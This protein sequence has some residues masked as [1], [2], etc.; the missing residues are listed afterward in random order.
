MVTKIYANAVAKYNEGKLLDEEKLRRLADSDFA[1]AVKML[2]DYGYGGGTADEKSYDAD[3][4]ISKETAA[5][6]DY[7]YSDAPDPYLARVL[8]ARFLFGNAKAYRKAKTSGVLQAEAVY[9]MPDDEVREGIT[10]GEYAALPAAMA[11]ALAEL[12]AKFGDGPE[13]P[14]EIDVALSK[15]M[16]AYESENAKKSRSRALKAFVSGEIDLKNIFTVL[17]ARAL[18]LNQSAVEPLLYDGGAWD[19]T[20]ILPLLSAEDPVAFLRDSAYDFLEEN[21]DTIDLPLMEAKSDAYL[22]RIWERGA[23]NMLSLSPFVRYFLCQMQEYKTVKLILACLRNGAKD[24]I[25]PRLFL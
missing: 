25:L 17:R 11:A 1:S 21:V 14:K 19:A 9:A 8:T 10:K 24:A 2:C 22:L 6:I 7:V 5:L 13:D 20:E 18:G 15:A 16:Y 3:A 23:E 4:F 12:D